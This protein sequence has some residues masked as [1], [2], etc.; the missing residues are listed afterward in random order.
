MFLTVKHSEC[1]PVVRVISGGLIT[2]CMLLSGFLSLSWLI[3]L[4]LGVSL[5]FTTVHIHLLPFDLSISQR[6][7]E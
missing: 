6:S 2:A 7:E 4:P 3:K 5:Q 1:E